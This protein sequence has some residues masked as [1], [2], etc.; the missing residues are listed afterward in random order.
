MLFT[1]LLANFPKIKKKKTTTAVYYRILPLQQR[2][3]FLLFFNWGLPAGLLTERIKTKK[4]NSHNST[5]TLTTI[6]CYNMFYNNNNNDYK[7]VICYVNNNNNNNQQ[8]T[9]LALL[10]TQYNHLQWF[11]P[12]A[13]YLWCYDDSVAV[14]CSYWCWCCVLVLETVFRV[15]HRL[16]VKRILKQWRT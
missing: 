13:V 11:L 8:L 5:T 12:Y 15:Y 16:W 2:N 10:L 6:L 1:L 3:D 14:V 7:Y 4:K 9:W